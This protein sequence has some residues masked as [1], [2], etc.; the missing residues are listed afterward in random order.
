[1]TNLSSSLAAIVLDRNTWH[2]RADQAWGSTRAWNS[3]TSFESAYNAE[4]TLY[5]NEVAAYNT[6][7]ANARDTSAGTH[8][9]GWASG[10]LWSTTASQWQT[11]YNNEV[12]AY[13]AGIPPAAT[14]TIAGTVIST[15]FGAITETVMMRCTADRSGNWFVSYWGHANGSDSTNH[16]DCNLYANGVSQGTRTTNWPVTIAERVVANFAGPFFLSAGQSAEARLIKTGATTLTV[17]VQAMLMVFVPT[18]ANPH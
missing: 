6:E 5:N 16:A 18:Q 1:M 2:L 14:V 17:D 10:Q 4:V 3:G 8:P 11:Q 9:S 12:A 7:Y 13:N 15:T